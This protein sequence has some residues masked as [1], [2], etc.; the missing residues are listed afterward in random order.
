MSRHEPSKN[1]RLRRPPRARS[2][3]RPPIRAHPAAILELFSLPRL[4]LPGSCAVV[5]DPSPSRR[6]SVAA[7][8]PAGL[9]ARASGVVGG[10]G[11]ARGLRRIA[12]SAVLSPSCSGI[13]YRQPTAGA[14]RQGSRRQGHCDGGC[15]ATRPL[16]ARPSAIGPCHRRPKCLIQARHPLHSRDAFDLCTA[17]GTRPVASP[18]KIVISLGRGAG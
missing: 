15:S 5:A 6:G 17:G 9:T 2:R 14:A 18:E 16:S 13:G 10:A 12:P 3:Q 11:R 8:P 4:G 1:R 7:V